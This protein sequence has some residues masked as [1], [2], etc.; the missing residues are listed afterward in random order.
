M[1]SGT[2]GWLIGGGV[3]LVALVGLGLFLGQDSGPTAPSTAAPRPTT[4]A[5][6][7]APPDDTRLPDEAPSAVPVEAWR[8][9]ESGLKLADL[10]VGDGQTAETGSP[11]IVEYTGWV[12]DSGE[13]IDSSKRRARPLLF[14]LGRGDAPIP[15]WDEAVSGMRVGGK[16]QA[17]F[18]PALAFGQTG[19]PPRIPR[20][21]SVVFEF[22]LKGVST[23]REAPEAPP[24]YSVADLRAVDGVQIVDLVE[25]TGDTLKRGDRI[26]LDYS[27]F[28]KSS[29]KRFDSSL[30]RQTPA[31]FKWGQEEML[32]GVELG[33]AGMKEGG[34]RLIQIPADLGYGEDGLRNYVPPDAELLFVV[35]LVEI[36]DG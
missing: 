19:R 23:R 7:E 36:D 16:R 32:Q 30:T 21:A 34:T 13:M 9:T 5:P 35:H 33:I 18:P 26:A 28:I 4:A 15:G 3:V 27:G 17:V 6:V 10:V 2:T 12:A 11:V 24:A 8:E 31:V 29:G 25:G 22:E 20:S 1:D 14:T